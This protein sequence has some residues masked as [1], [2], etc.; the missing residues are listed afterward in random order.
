M[1]IVNGFL[2][3]LTTGVFCLTWCI[4]A[5][6]PLILSKGR[7]IKQSFFI[8]LKFTFGRLIGYILF[9]GL[10]GYLGLA[11][12]SGVIKKINLIALILLAILLILHGIGWIS[13]KKSCC[14]FFKKVK[15][16]FLFGFLIG[17]NIC[18]PFLLALTYVF[19][20]GGIVNGILFFISF[21]I[22]TSLYL[23]PFV[24]LGFLASRKIFQKIAR[25]IAIFA[26]I[27]FLVYGLKGLFFDDYP[28]IDASSD[29]KEASYYQSLD[30]GVVQCELCPRECILA[31]G[32]RGF[33]RVRQNIEGKLYSLVYNKPVAIHLDPIEKKPL[34]HFLPGTTAYSVATVGCNLRCLYCQNWEISQSF[35]ED[36]KSVNRTPEQLVAEAL[37]SGAQS[38]AY[39]Y[40]EP[41]VFYEYM[42]ET[43]KLARLKGLKNVVISAGYINPEPLK[44]L[45][46]YVDAIKIDLKAFNNDFYKRIVGGKL[47]PVLESLKVVKEQGVWLEIVYLVIPGENDNPEE[48]KNMAQ[49]IKENLGENVP[50]HFSRFHPTYK[51]MNLPPTPEET[52]RKLRQI[53][54]DE[55]LKYVYT[56]NLGDWETESTYCPGSQEIA[57]KRQGFFIVED[58]IKNGA[59]SNGKIIPG[60]WK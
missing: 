39:T 57:I 48:I 14:Q 28:S 26:G 34:F 50:L 22:A 58:N 30:D 6:L 33:C 43:A 4:P 9:G 46:K 25:F 17:I 12:K 56:G 52:V 16:P 7:K 38:I 36:A 2:L 15:F 49:W 35:P 45:C 13:R 37:A 47:E 59:C 18:P 27:F 10:V 42:T 19:D 44:E 40:S 5:L 41:T 60:V 29:L 24:F 54:I 8:F 31:P 23:V 51:L 1:F 32:Q 55:G 53:A 20:I 3:G 11:I 21:F